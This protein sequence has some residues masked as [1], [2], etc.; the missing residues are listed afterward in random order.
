MSP[1]ASQVQH[2][3][4]VNMGFFFLCSAIVGLTQLMDSGSDCLFPRAV[5]TAD[6][7]Q[8]RGK[9]ANTP[10]G[11]TS[12]C[13]ESCVMIIRPF[14]LFDIVD[15]HQQAARIHLQ[16]S[17]FIIKKQTSSGNTG[18]VTKCIL[19][20]TS[21]VTGT[22]IRAAPLFYLFS[23]SEEQY[24]PLHHR[25]FHQTKVTGSSSDTAKSQL[26]FFSRCLWF[27][28]QQKG[29]AGLYDL[30]PIL[31]YIL[32]AIVTNVTYSSNTWKMYND[33]YVLL[34]SK[35]ETSRCVIS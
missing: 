2:L 26:A 11:M 14:L 30:K 9:R 31:E 20:W 33:K 34:S 29:P 3:Y 16:M 19:E 10:W 7:I 4:W 5:S 15:K 22:F 24:N 35:D 32:I 6:W 13:Q 1:K 18:T 25:R 12:L 8:L 23:Y 27:W 21:V 28:I 17:Q